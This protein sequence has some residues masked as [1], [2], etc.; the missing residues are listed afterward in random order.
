MKTVF[1]IGLF[2]SGIYL[3]FLGID[4]I[5]LKSVILNTNNPDVVQT[6]ASNIS[7][8]SPGNYFGSILMGLVFIVASLIWWYKDLKNIKK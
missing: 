8:A 1:R 4:G 5:Y 2:L 3:L 6:L 7:P